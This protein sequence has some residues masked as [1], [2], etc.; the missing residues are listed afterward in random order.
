M[1]VI[2]TGFYMTVN[3]EYMYNQYMADWYLF[4]KHTYNTCTG[5]VVAI[6]HTQHQVYVNL[7]VRTREHIHLTHARQRV[8][9]MRYNIVSR[10]ICYLQVLC[11]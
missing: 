5:K 11:M 3:R 10:G 7:K 6:T 4:E 2:A 8:E 1:N 9:S